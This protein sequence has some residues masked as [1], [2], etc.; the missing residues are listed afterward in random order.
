MERHG[1]ATLGTGGALA[2]AAAV[3]EAL[4]AAPEA[5]GLAIRA[6]EFA[7]RTMLERTVELDACLGDLVELSSA[8]E[9]DRLALAQY[10]LRF[11]REH[12]AML[13]TIAALY[14]REGGPPRLSTILAEG[15][16]LRV[17]AWCL[18]VRTHDGRLL[19]VGHFVADA[20]RG[21][22]MHGICDD[23]ARRTK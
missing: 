13:E 7:A 6:H 16:S 10:R 21:T 20:M 2:L 18:S 11:V 22:V 14:E 12:E 23:C 4:R 3:G 8:V 17:C 1:V 15:G 19:P 5:A 9:E